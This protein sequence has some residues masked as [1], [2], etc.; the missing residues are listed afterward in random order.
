M[1]FEQHSLK[2]SEVLRS[3]FS[4]RK[5]ER[6]QTELLTDSFVARP[7]TQAQQLAQPGNSP[8]FSPQYT[9]RVPQ[10]PGTSLPQ[11]AEQDKDASSFQEQP[12]Y[13]PAGTPAGTLQT[14]ARCG[15][16]TKY[17]SDFY[18]QPAGELQ[19]SGPTPSDQPVPCCLQTLSFDC[20]V[21][22]GNMQ[23]SGGVDKRI[24]CSCLLRHS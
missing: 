13:D 17:S 3:P 8:R 18:S 23:L 22:M 5:R 15:K 6:E 24:C 10:M 19:R 20:A 4:A 2:F 16:P 1:A 14:G 21:Q 12:R 11:P 7:T 9:T